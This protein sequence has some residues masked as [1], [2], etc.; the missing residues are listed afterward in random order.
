MSGTQKTLRILDFPKSRV[1]M[2][3]SECMCVW[4]CVYMY[5]CGCVCI[6]ICVVEENSGKQELLHKG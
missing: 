4:L 2:N 5:M 6:C 3:E 1:Y